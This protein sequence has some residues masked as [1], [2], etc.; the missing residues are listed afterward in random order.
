MDKRAALMGRRLERLEFSAAAR[1]QAE[2][3]DHPNQTEF[4][5]PDYVDDDGHEYRLV[6]RM[7]AQSR[8]GG[9]APGDP[10]PRATGRTSADE[11]MD[12]PQK[13]WV[14]LKYGDPGRW[15]QVADEYTARRLQPLHLDCDPIYV[16]VVSAFRDSPR[17]RTGYIIVTVEKAM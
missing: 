8:L 3:A 11:L 2:R 7:E 14:R 4:G 17:R 16:R 5:A 12:G 15:E 13:L 9:W 1:R 6:T 10:M